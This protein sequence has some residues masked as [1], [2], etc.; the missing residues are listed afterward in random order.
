[1]TILSARKPNDRSTP[2]LKLRKQPDGT[3]EIMLRDPD[4]AS[5]ATAAAKTAAAPGGVAPGALSPQTW[6]WPLPLVGLSDWIPYESMLRS[7]LAAHPLNIQKALQKGLAL[8]LTKSSIKGVS[9]IHF[10][11][12]LKAPAVAAFPSAEELLDEESE[13]TK[14]SS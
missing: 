7:I 2:K 14:G 11:M 5:A 10:D 12:E 3:L 1:M 8:R 9:L 6:A 13:C 4:A